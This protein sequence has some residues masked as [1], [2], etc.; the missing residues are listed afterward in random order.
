MQDMDPTTALTGELDDIDL[1]VDEVINAFDDFLWK[2]K[3]KLPNTEPASDDWVDQRI[4]YGQ[5]R[6]ELEDTIYS[7]LMVYAQ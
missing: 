5:Q 6:E 7:I 4:I 2:F 3:A 1:E